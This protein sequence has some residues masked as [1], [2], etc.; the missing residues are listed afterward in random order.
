MQIKCKKPPSWP[1][2]IT[3]SLIFKKLETLLERVILLSS[4]GVEGVFKPNWLRKPYSP[5]IMS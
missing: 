2:R 4:E 3:S 5:P 1:Q